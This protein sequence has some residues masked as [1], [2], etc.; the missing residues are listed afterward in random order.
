MLA[1]KSREG[2]GV[3][4]GIAM[5]KEGKHT[6]KHLPH[7]E[8]ALPLLAVVLFA[9]LFVVWPLVDFGLLMRPFPG[10]VFLIVTLSGLYAFGTHGRALT[11]VL[12]L[13]GAVFVL[14]T[15][16]LVWDFEALSILREVA[17]ELFVLV[18]CG[19]LLNGVMRPGRVTTNRIVGAVVVYVL[20]ALQFAFLF[21]LVERFQ[22]GAF[23]MGQV[24]STS[25]W[26]GWRFFYLSVITLSSLGLS[27]ITPINPFARSLVMLEALLGQMYTTVLLARLV[28]LEVAD[29]IRNMPSEN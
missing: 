13:G 18:L 7:G 29:R 15:L 25:T 21:A 1:C 6:M 24:S 16:T 8:A 4:E 27:D 2:A 11:S 19:V 9:L 14:Q 5:A 22:P 17:A 26:T 23:I 3:K 20:F 10:I 12:T 28:S